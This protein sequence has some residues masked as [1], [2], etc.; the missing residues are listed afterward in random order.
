MVTEMEKKVELELRKKKEQAL[1][2]CNDNDFK[3][4][5]DTAQDN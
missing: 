4:A 2:E 1:E 3:S 5:E